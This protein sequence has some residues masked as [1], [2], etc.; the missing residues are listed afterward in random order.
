MSARLPSVLPL[1][2][3]IAAAVLGGYAFAATGA[4]WL[5]FALPAERAQAVLTGLLASFALY[6]AAVVWAF[7]ART[8]VHAWAGLLLPTLAFAGL[9]WLSGLQGAP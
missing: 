8:A 2:A 1:L 4:V 9:A 3:R 7:A 6:A 5:A